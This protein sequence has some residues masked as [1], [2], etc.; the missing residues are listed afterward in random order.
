M[1]KRLA[2]LSITVMIALS[3]CAE[4]NN[5]NNNNAMNNSVQGNTHSDMNHSSSSEVPEGLHEAMDPI[6]PVG[7]QA[8]IKDDHMEGMKD[9]TATIVGAYDTIAYTV[10]Y[11]PTTGGER[12]TNHKWVIHEEIEAA[13]EKPY[14]PGDEVVL[15]A[16]HMKGMK[17]AAAVVDSNEQ[18][19]V[20]MIDFNTTTDGELVKNHKWV[21]ENEL[22]AQ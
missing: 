5:T 6:Y 19:T 17:G 16:E 3:G 22:S 12:V 20:Y 15:E 18:T 1:K 11:T 2:I 9:A 8:I 21:T 13:A 7:S 14:E 4:G 10:S